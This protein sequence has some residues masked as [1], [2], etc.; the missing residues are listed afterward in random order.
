MSAPPRETANAQSAQQPRATREE[1]RRVERE[2]NLQAVSARAGNINSLMGILANLSVSVR[3]NTAVANAPVIQL[4]TELFTASRKTFERE[5]RLNVG[6]ARERAGL[7]RNAGRSR[8]ERG[9]GGREPGPHG[10]SAAGGHTAGYAGGAGG[11]GLVPSLGVLGA[12]GAAAGPR[13]SGPG[14]LDPVP[15]PVPAAPA[16]AAHRTANAARIAANAARIA[17]EQPAGPPGHAALLPAPVPAGSA[18]AAAAAAAATA[19]AAAATAAPNPG[20][21][22]A[23]VA[24]RTAAADDDSAS[25]GGAR[26]L[27]FMDTRDGSRKRLAPSAADKTSGQ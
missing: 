6:D 13:D 9:G 20:A 17:A 3:D 1:T 4:A 25:R 11:S 12:V 22:A 26:E 18:A 15:Q 21:G 27:E 14:P 24:A 23:A 10:P 7:S 19:A 2:I 8:R 5:L 16:A